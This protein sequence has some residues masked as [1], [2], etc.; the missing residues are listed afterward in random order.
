MYVIT[1]IAKLI[2]L[3]YYNILFT[4]LLKLNKNENKHKI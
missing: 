2:T 3:S 1:R 4:F